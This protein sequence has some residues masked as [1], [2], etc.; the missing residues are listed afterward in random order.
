[1]ITKLIWKINL[2][3]YLAMFHKIF[4][5]DDTIENNILFGKQSFSKD[6]KKL[7]YALNNSQLDQFIK[8]LQRN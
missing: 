4:L 7:N 6:D 8:Q 3:I 2:I 5:L 1:M